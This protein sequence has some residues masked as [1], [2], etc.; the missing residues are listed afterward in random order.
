MRTN[1]KMASS[2]CFFVYA[3]VLLS[4]NQQRNFTFQLSKIDKPIAQ[5]KGNWK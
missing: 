5:T 4:D 3:L 1:K 2:K